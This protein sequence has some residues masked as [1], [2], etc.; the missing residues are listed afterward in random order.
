MSLRRCETLSLA[1]GEVGRVR[2]HRTLYLVDRTRV[3]LDRVE[4]LGHFLELEVVMSSSESSQSGVEVAYRL[5]DRLGIE[6]SQLIEGAYVDL[7]KELT[8]DSIGSNQGAAKVFE[9]RSW[10]N[11]LWK[12]RRI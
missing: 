8:I 5:L 1:Y 12:S 10:G 4:D 11:Q 9:F 2:K 6:L 3:H 7:L